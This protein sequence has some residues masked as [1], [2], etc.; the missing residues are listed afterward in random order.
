MNKETWVKDDCATAHGE[1]H[2]CTG[3]AER[4]LM[5]SVESKYALRRA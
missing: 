5:I 4:V 2:Y 1:R 3:R